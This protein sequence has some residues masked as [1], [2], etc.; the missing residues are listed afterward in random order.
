MG[1]NPLLK[2]FIVVVFGGL[3]SLPGT[4]V[5]SYVISLIESISTYYIGLY[6]TPPVLFAILIGVMLVRPTGLLGRAH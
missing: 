5:G 1:D 6:W 2:A 4:V 3:G